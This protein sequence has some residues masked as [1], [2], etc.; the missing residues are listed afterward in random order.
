MTLKTPFSPDVG[1]GVS[2]R[3]GAFS[4]VQLPA[5]GIAEV[6]L[7]AGGEEGS[8]SSFLMGTRLWG[9]ECHTNSWTCWV[10]GWLLENQFSEAQSVGRAAGLGETWAGVGRG[11]VPCRWSSA[12]SPAPEALLG[13]TSPASSLGL[14]LRLRD[15]VLPPFWAHGEEKKPSPRGRVKPSGT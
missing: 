6:I 15:P 14:D 3:G 5:P 4:G 12:P 9:R 10:D 1:R 8:R 7:A 13:V 2:G 11:S